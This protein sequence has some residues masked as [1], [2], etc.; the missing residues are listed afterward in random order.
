MSSPTMNEEFK[1]PKQ[2]A[3]ICYSQYHRTS[4]SNTFLFGEYVKEAEWDGIEFD[5]FLI[6]K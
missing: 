5:N 4:V 1:D 6:L 3:S 2:R